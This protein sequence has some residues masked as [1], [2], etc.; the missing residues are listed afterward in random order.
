MP[1]V[2]RY[3]NSQSVRSEFDAVRAEGVK[4]VGRS[5]QQDLAGARIASGSRSVAVYCDTT[6]TKIGRAI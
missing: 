6:R 4:P 5:D 2:G 1:G 3:E